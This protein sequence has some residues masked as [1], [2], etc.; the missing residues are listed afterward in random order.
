[1]LT[2]QEWVSIVNIIFGY[3]PPPASPISVLRN[4]GGWW[5]NGSRGERGEYLSM[6]F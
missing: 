6:S 1:M 2:I 5:G 4:G 3:F